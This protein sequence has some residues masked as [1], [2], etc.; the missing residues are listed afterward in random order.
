MRIIA[1]PDKSYPTMRKI[2]FV[3]MA[4]PFNLFGHAQY[5]VNS[6]GK[7]AGTYIIQFLQAI[8]PIRASYAMV[9][10]IILFIRPLTITLGY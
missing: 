4:I 2:V 9:R 10:T 7:D 5:P 6:I 1:T 3:I 8:I